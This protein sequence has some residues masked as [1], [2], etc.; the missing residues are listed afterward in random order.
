[1]RVRYERTSFFFSLRDGNNL[2]LRYSLSFDLALLNPTTFIYFCF[3]F[4]STDF[5]IPARMHLQRDLWDRAYLVPVR[6]QS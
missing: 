6:A 2:L 5:I 3:F 4:N 1:M